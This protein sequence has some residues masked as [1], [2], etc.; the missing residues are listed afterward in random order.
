[1]RAELR[2]MQ[3]TLVDERVRNIEWEDAQAGRDQ[4]TSGHLA[5]QQ[6]VTRMLVELVRDKVVPQQNTQAALLG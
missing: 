1:M 2:E 6:A 3:R 4:T 5:H